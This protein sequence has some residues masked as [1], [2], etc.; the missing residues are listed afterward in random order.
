MELMR[1]RKSA[2][3]PGLP[4]PGLLVVKSIFLSWK[5]PLS[6]IKM[7][8][9][10]QGQGGWG[11]SGD[12]PPVSAAYNTAPEK[13]ALF[14]IARN[15]P[16]LREC[17]RASPQSRSAAGCGEKVGMSPFQP[18]FPS[19]TTDHCGSCP[20]SV[21]QNVLCSN[22]D[23]PNKMIQL[24]LKADPRCLAKFQGLFGVLIEYSNSNALRQRVSFSPSHIN[25]PSEPKD[26][27]HC[28]NVP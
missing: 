24:G 20:C 4:P 5:F 22:A 21:P 9:R 16:R 11:G 10:R 7:A 8:K 25:K 2:F 19:A 18:P 23:S 6:L 1:S 14:K 17:P 28:R 13:D 27:P 15:L 3:S 12:L 26:G